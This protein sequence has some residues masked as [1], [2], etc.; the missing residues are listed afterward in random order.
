M[1]SS[2]SSFEGDIYDNLEVKNNV[3]GIKDNN[4]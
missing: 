2:D 1:L 4:R 3:S